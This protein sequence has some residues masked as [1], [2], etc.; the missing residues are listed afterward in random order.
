VAERPL[1][2]Q[3]G[4]LTDVIDPAVGRLLQL[5]RDAGVLDDT[6]VLFVAD[7]GHTPVLNDAQHAL[8][9]EGEDDPVAVLEQAGFRMR[10]LKLELQD[11][12]QDFQTT[13]AYQG[14][15]AYVYLADR[16]TCT[17]PGTRCDWSR[18]PRLE[19]DVLPVVRAFDAAN[20]T[21][22][23]VPAL[24]GTLDLIFARPPRPPAED[25]LPFQV[26]DGEALVDLGVWLE[27]NPR[28]DLLDLERRLHAL[29]A[30]PYGHRAGD[31]LLLAKSGA[32][33]P[34]D[35]RY[36]FSARY[37]SWHGS[38]D[39]QDSRI[40]LLVAHG[41]NDGAAIRSRVHAAAG[42]QPHQEDI[43]ALVLD[44]LRR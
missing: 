21:G 10:A 8:G 2:M 37:R 40:P 16:S 13:V 39:E 23:G 42:P 1:E 14:A 6:W 25:A 31:V 26:W 27:R 4:Y 33:R 36:Y 20:R 28:P 7:H 18:A 44:L 38:P 3:R 32:A 22:A 24:R 15:F 30:G 29:A 9:A 34:I 17:Q 35:E 41:G 19:Q 43:T 12:E 11:D 5:Y